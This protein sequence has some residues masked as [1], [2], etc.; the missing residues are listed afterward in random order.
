MI[1]I[2]TDSAADLPDE[3]VKKHRLRIVPLT[4]TIDGVEYREGIDI[5]TEEFNKKMASSKTLPQTSQ[6]AAASFASAFRELAPKGELICITISS[7]LS[8]TYPVRLPGQ[9]DVGLRCG[10]F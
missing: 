9:G 8:G 1:Q 3:L 4:V 7:K 6:P 10:R 5:T 2:I